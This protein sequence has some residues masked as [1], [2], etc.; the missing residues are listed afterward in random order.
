MQERGEQPGD[1]AE[2]LPR[3]SYRFTQPVER[4]GMTFARVQHCTSVEAPLEAGLTPACDI[5][6]LHLT[7]MRGSA[8]SDGR[9]IH[10]G[11]IEAHS[12]SLVKTG[13]RSDVELHGPI[14]IVQVF[15]APDILAQLAAEVLARPAHPFIDGWIFDRDLA[16]LTLRAFNASIS[17]HPASLLAAESLALEIGQRIL[18]RHSRDGRSESLARRHGG[19]PPWRM[20]QLIDYVEHHLSGELSLQE[21]ACVAHLSPF[22]FLRAFQ[23]ETGVTPH[24]W[25]MRRRIA[26]SKQLLAGSDLAIS[27]IAAEVGYGSQS[28]FTAAFSSTVGCSPRE[29]RR[30]PTD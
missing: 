11:V 7:S 2:R 28:A 5:L 23:A 29:W 15:L 21:L 26:R 8:W 18:R 3:G 17:T 13:V 27:E 1:L 14:D 22:H 16:T 30:R 9:L 6:S 25:V 19:I 4:S 20:R 24:R 12:I 10:K